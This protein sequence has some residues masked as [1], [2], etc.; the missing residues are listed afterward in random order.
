[1]IIQFLGK[2]KGEEVEEGLVVV[3]EN[4]AHLFLSFGEFPDFLV[5]PPFNPGVRTNWAAIDDHPRFEDSV[6]GV[7]RSRH[8]LRC[9]PGQV[10][11]RENLTLRSLK[12]ET[13]TLFDVDTEAIYGVEH[14]V[15]VTA[16]EDIILSGNSTASIDTDILIELH[17][18]WLDG[19]VE[20]LASFGVTLDNTFTSWGSPYLSLVD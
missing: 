1:M 12:V 4:V 14:E 7:A 10:V 15:S 11:H 16:N 20:A 6:D 2:G 5:Q 3:T 13:T 9:L 18:V 19:D 17:E 8:V